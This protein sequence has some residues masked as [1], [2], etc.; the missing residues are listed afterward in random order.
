MK[1]EQ[2]YWLTREGMKWFW[3]NYTSN[4]TNL[5]DPKVSPLHASNEQLSGLP[6]AL[7]INARMMYFVMRAKHMRSSYWRQVFVLLLFD[8][9][10]S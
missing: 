10:A 1:Y 5:K 8:I 7:I 6:P 9:M 3:K 2:G 4:Q